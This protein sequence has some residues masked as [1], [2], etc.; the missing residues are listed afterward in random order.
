MSFTNTPNDDD[1]D[2]PSNPQQIC[3]LSDMCPSV[4]R[5]TNS[6]EKVR[7]TASLTHSVS[8]PDHSG[9]GSKDR[10]SSSEN[11][12]I[13][14][15]S[16]IVLPHR[17][18]KWAT[19]QAVAEMTASEQE[20][21][22]LKLA[23]CGNLSPSE[24]LGARASLPSESRAPHQA[25]ATTSCESESPSNVGSDSQVATLGVCCLVCRRSGVSS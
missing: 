22:T 5:R 12:Q 3:C 8:A 6:K 23:V 16:A 10:N 25:A 17:E 7:R 21:D 4:R 14:V 24:A 20:T 19:H 1:G 18:E 2:V 9:E 11:R 15:V 13:I